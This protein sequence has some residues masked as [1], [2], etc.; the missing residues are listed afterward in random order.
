MIQKI[1]DLSLNDINFNFDIK[2]ELLI[3]ED[4]FTDVIK[5]QINDVNINESE[6]NKLNIDKKEIVKEENNKQL[7]FDEKISFIDNENQKIRDDLKQFDEINKEEEIKKDSE[8]E[9]PNLFVNDLAN[10]DIKNIEADFDLENMDYNDKDDII[11]SIEQKIAQDADQIKNLEN[12]DFSQI[13]QI[14]DSEKENLEKE[15]DLQKA[16]TLIENDKIVINKEKHEQFFINKEEEK[17]VQKLNEMDILNK[18]M[19]EIAKGID[20][21][22]QSIMIND[23]IEEIPEIKEIGLLDKKEEIKQE[24]LYDDKIFEKKD[25][26][27]LKIEEE[28]FFEEAQKVD[29]DINLNLDIDSLDLDNLN[30]DNLNL[31]DI[32]LDDINLSDINL[33][34]SNLEKLDSMENIDVGVLE[35]KEEENKLKENIQKFDMQ[36]QE[37]IKSEGDNILKVD[38]ILNQEL[39]EALDSF[40]QEE[41]KLNKNQDLDKI[42]IDIFNIL[43]NPKVDGVV[44]IKDSDF[45]NYFI[46]N[47]IFK[48]KNFKYLTELNEF[49]RDINNYYEEL[50]NGIIFSWVFENKVIIIYGKEGL[51]IGI[52]KAKLNT[53]NNIFN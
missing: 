5:D 52:V 35:I 7:L 47:S 46:D 44:V 36:L 19:E 48:E 16:P 18:E 31:D 41:R 3:K 2:Q 25:K 53:I 33:D 38:N 27:I 8:L 12:V 30:L 10:I 42:S 50:E 32:N 22:I 14:I 28:I 11:Q 20:R 23:K 4:L 24:I 1:E 49:I 40:K 6:F 34:D 13:S 43:N 17:E 26:D 39:K 51:M 15:I 45:G 9:L 21:E 29:I 37:E